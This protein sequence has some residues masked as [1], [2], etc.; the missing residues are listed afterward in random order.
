MAKQRHRDKQRWRRS[1]IYG[2]ERGGGVAGRS[3]WCRRTRGVYRTD[4]TAHTLQIREGE[5]AV[6]AYGESDVAAW[7]GRDELTGMQVGMYVTLPAKVL[8]SE[9]RPSRNGPFV[10]ASVE[11]KDARK[12]QLRMWE[13]EVADVPIDAL[14]VMHGLKMVATQ[15][16]D[17]SGS[18]VAKE[19]G[20]AVGGVHDAVCAGGGAP[21][22]VRDEPW[23]VTLS[24]HMCM[25]I[26]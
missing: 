15:T 13:R 17:D 22:R 20:R 25:L 7:K 8:Y 24:L 2:R 1:M 18:W 10:L 16:K 26:F 4:T 3:R 12:E 5:E 11:Y 23:R 6:V 21:G 14:V 9:S 19:G